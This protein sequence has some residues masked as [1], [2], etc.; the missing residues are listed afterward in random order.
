MGY[1]EKKSRQQK[2]YDKFVTV[3]SYFYYWSLT[4]APSNNLFLSPEILWDKTFTVI[5]LRASCCFGII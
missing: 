3:G 2:N 4:Q 5:V 1:P